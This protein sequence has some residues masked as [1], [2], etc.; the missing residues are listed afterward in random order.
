MTTNGLGSVP[1]E[2]KIMLLYTGNIMTDEGRGGYLNTPMNKSNA[3][4]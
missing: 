3:E 4:V 1:K 2:E